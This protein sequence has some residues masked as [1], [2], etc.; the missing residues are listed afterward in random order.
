M[1][2]RAASQSLGHIAE[3]IDDAEI[4]RQ[5]LLPAF[6]DLTHDGK[7]PVFV[8]VNMRRTQISVCFEHLQIRTQCV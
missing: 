3:V 6:I 8:N 5:E 7:P 1:V 4:I 2:R